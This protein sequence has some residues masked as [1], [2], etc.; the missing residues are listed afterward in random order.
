MLLAGEAGAQ[1]G[2]GNLQTNQAGLYPVEI[3][4]EQVDAGIAED[5][6]DLQH[7]RRGA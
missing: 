7:F 2:L 3:S 5:E 4:R 6:A 1:W